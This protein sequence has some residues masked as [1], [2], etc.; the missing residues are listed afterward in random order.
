MYCPG[1]WVR[2]IP[3]DKVGALLGQVIGI[4]PEVRNVRDLAGVIDLKEAQAWLSGPICVGE[5]DPTRGE[6]TCAN[7]PDDL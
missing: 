5:L 4:R 7:D 6:L 1:R 2:S 3:L